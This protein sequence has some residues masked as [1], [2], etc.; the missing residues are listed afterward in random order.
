MFLLK[1]G[2]NNFK[3]GQICDHIKKVLFM[4]SAQ[5]F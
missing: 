3:L 2:I 5:G 1:G 4:I